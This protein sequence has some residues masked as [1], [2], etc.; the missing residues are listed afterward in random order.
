VEHHH[1]TLFANCLSQASAM[2]AG[3][4]RAEA[5][6]ELLQAGLASADAK[7][8]APHKEIPGNK[9]SNILVMDKITPTTLGAVIALYEHRTFVQ[10]VIWDIDC[11]DQWG[12]ELG[13]QIGNQILPRLLGDKFEGTAGDSATD[14]MIRLFRSANRP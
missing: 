2:M 13:K 6:Q 10:S 3:K 12:V 11:F 7:A 9:P 4:T 8:L 1:A 5:E 14:Q